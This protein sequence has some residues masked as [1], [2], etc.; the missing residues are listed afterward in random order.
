M[1]PE[2]FQTVKMWSF[3]YLSYAMIPQNSHLLFA[4]SAP[5]HVSARPLALAGG[6]VHPG[7]LIRGL[8]GRRTCAGYT[9]FHPVAPACV[10]FVGTFRDLHG[11]IALCRNPEW[12]EPGLYVGWNLAAV[13]GRDI[14]MAL[15]HAVMP[16]ARI[17]NTDVLYLDAELP[18]AECITDKYYWKRH[19][20]NA[21]REVRETR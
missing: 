18:P 16:A 3:N 6:S 4:A 7:Q 8:F 19:S 14:L 13:E 21:P 11:E 9:N 10:R 1:S 15:T 12:D 17:V 5:L 2:L 20:P